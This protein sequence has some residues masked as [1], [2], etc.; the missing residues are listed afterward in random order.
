[1]TGIIGSVVTLFV[2]GLSQGSDLLDPKIPLGQI[3]GGI[4]LSL[5]M[6]TV[7][8][9]VLLGANLLLLVNF[10]RTACACCCKTTAES[11]QNL[12]RQPVALEA[13]AS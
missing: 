9:I 3:F 11:P 5:L 8:Q 2:A 13:H 1:M 12:F 6:N 10:C 7:A 4:R